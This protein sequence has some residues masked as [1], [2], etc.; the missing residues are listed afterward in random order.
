M[1][2]HITK[3]S[4]EYSSKVYRSARVVVFAVD[5]YGAVVTYN[6][7]VGAFIVRLKMLNINTRIDQSQYE[8]T[9]KTGGFGTV[10][11]ARSPNGGFV[12]KRIYFTREL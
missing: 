6:V 12:S 3:T 5:N 10:I 2:N 7:V 11:L 9:V 8:R 1:N 4:S